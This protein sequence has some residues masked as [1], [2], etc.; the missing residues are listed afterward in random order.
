VPLQ[1]ARVPLAV[2]VV[3][4]PS[5][6][7]SSIIGTAAGIHTASCV[8][9]NTS[10]SDRYVCS[11]VIGVGSTDFSLCGFGVGFQGEP[12]EVKTTQAEE[13]VYN[14]KSRHVSG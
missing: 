14:W 10:W 1:A 9:L 11:F 3:R 6:A 5:A 7:R 12:S 4:E 2:S 8:P 13:F